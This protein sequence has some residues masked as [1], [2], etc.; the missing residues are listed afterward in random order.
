MTFPLLRRLQLPEL[1]TRV[2]PDLQ[3]RPDLT[4]LHVDNVVCLF[5]V[6]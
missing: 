1:L 5:I 3:A 6:H 4:L 2:D